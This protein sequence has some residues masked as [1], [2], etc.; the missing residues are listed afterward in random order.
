[1][2]LQARETIRR[3]LSFFF[4]KLNKSRPPTH[5][6]NGCQA[7]RRARGGRADG[8][9]VR[10]EV[11]VAAHHNVQNT[12][13]H[14]RQQYT[15]KNKKRVNK[16]CCMHTSKYMVERRKQNEE[17]KECRKDHDRKRKGT[18]EKKES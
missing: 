3:L 15:M 10:Q 7:V 11:V 2:Y 13:L 8:V 18:R 6:D 5:L 4:G 1:M 12:F 9:L 14:A 16:Q 17:G